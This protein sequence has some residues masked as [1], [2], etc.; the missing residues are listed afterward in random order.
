MCSHPHHLSV[1]LGT[2]CT[3]YNAHPSLWRNA[4]SKGMKG[5]KGVKGMKGM[6][7]MKVIVIEYILCV[8]PIN[9]KSVV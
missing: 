4:R 7:G 1:S 2:A 9:V 5:V 3:N 8:W 6:K